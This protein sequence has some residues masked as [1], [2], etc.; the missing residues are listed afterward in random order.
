MKI[1]SLQS[2]FQNELKRGT[3]AWEI[4]SLRLTLSKDIQPD[5]LDV[6]SEAS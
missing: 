4:L 2:L 5:V 6:K 1:N 3:K